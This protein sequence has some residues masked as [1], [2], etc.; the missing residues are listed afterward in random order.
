MTD[1]HLVPLRDATDAALGGGK[2]VNL[3]AM[4][5]AGLPVPDGF[6][7]TAAAYRRV[8]DE[9]GIRR[10]LADITVAAATA[11]VGEL[12]ELA[13]TARELVRDISLPDD[14]VAE[15]TDMYAAHCHG[16]PVAVR[17]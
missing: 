17:S 7:V 5:R 11:D 8:V 4:I 15:V 3:A 9:S 1:A 12:A 14:L 13:R 10:R 6:V 2:A 16:V